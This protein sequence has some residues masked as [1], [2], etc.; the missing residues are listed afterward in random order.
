MK[1]GKYLKLQRMRLIIY[2]MIITS[3][4]FSGCNFSGE[5]AFPDIS[6]YTSHEISSNDLSQSNDEIPSGV[7][8]VALP[9]SDA[10]LKY[11]TSMYI[12]EKAGLFR[13]NH[14]DLTGLTITDEILEE[15]D[16]GIVSEL[17]NVSNKGFNSQEIRIFRSA[18]DLPDIYLLSGYNTLSSQWIDLPEL[19]GD[20]LNN[21][22]NSSYVIPEMFVSDIVSGSVKGIP[23]YASLM[24]LYA[25]RDLMTEKLDDTSL[26]T[27]PLTFQTMRKI[28]ES[29]FDKEQNI[30]GFRGI[31]ELLAF[32]P[33]TVNPFSES[34]A[35]NNGSFDFKNN[36]FTDSLKFLTEFSWTGSV[37]DQLTD[38]ELFELFGASDPR[39]LGK[40]CF[41]IDDSANVSRWNEKRNIRMLPIPFVDR[42]D[43]PVHVYPVAV[44]PDSDLLDQAKE[45][46][47]YLALDKDALLFRSRYK[48]EE[49]FIPPLSDQDVWQEIVSVQKAG[50]DLMMLRNFTNS[51]KVSDP[52]T[53]DNVKNI[54]DSIYD[55][56]FYDIIFNEE[57]FDENISE[58]E[59]MAEEAVSGG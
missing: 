24:M 57:T 21:Y 56:Y 13:N 1:S 16:S 18:G 9:L 27:Y 55:K 53:P 3:V 17:V 36:A 31:K 19:S 23:F 42:M 50:D 38:Q 49:G 45:L 11:L 40:I 4:F 43:L 35:W 14:T 58:I 51:M 15:Y 47:I 54:F 12:G 7:L 25:D 41:W 6:Y 44:D 8:K 46:A 5:A 2:L 32:L 26:F 20:Y 34:Y 48:N 22:L 39:E 30:Y 10:C 37:L 29:V 28:S 59:R 33:G 52:F